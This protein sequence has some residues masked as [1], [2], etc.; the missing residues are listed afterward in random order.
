[1]RRCPAPAKKKHVG[2]MAWGSS[3]PVVKMQS[4]CV[5]VLPSTEVALLGTVLLMLAR[6]SAGTISKDFVF[7]AHLSVVVDLGESGGQILCGDLHG[8]GV[9]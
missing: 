2:G 9:H 4:E 8:W 7:N 5:A 6:G 1:M 3:F